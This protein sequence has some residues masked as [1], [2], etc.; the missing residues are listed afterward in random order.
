[1]LGENMKDINQDCRKQTSAASMAG[2]FVP[3]EATCARFRAVDKAYKIFYIQ[4]FG[5]RRVNVD[6]KKKRSFKRH[7]KQFIIRFRFKDM[8]DKRQ[9]VSAAS[10]PLLYRLLKLCLAF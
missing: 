5:F 3:N 1:M 10:S 6:K 7:S 9:W 4:G 8:A 2:Q